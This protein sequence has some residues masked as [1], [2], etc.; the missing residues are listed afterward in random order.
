LLWL[1]G[2]KKKHA[3]PPGRLNDHS[4]SSFAA[5]EELKK[6]EVDLRRAQEYLETAQDQMLQLQG[7]KALQVRMSCMQ[8]P[9]SYFEARCRI[10]ACVFS[11]SGAVSRAQAST[12]W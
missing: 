8:P 5:Q 6:Q 9:T 2:P 12:S 1:C 11:L 4:S 10:F 7:D 3:V